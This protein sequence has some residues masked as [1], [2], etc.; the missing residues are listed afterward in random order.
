MPGNILSILG[1]FM[2]SFSC[3][4]LT[5]MMVGVVSIWMD[6]LWGRVMGQNCDF[7]GKVPKSTK[8]PGYYPPASPRSQQASEKEKHRV[9]ISQIQIAPWMVWA[10]APM[11]IGRYSTHKW[12][13]YPPTPLIKKFVQ[14]PGP[15]SR[16][17]F[18][19]DFLRCF[20]ESKHQNL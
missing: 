7:T 14:G 6:G 2:R 17:F 8:M 1:N 9:W 19:K 18:S 11:S 3:E 10:Q 15:G 5:E 16:S 20:L 4:S 13:G 12:R